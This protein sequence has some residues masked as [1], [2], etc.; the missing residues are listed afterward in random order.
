MG[1]LV[2]EEAAPLPLAVP[3]ILSGHSLAPVTGVS[4]AR[5]IG[6]WRSM[7]EE[8]HYALPVWVRPV[9]FPIAPV[10]NKPG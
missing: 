7:S 3:K 5:A 10:D 1:E 8:A 9:L 6:P 4:P 2:A